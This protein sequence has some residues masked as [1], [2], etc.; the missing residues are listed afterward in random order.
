MRTN[1]TYI[2]VALI[3][4]IGIILAGYLVGNMHLNGLKYQRYVSVKGLAER[5]VDANLAIWAFRMTIASNE[6]NFL[7]KK[8]EDDTRV[9]EN[10]LS[11]EGF[12]T[13]EF[14]A[15]VAEIQDLQTFSYGSPN[16]S[17]PFR[18]IAKKDFTIRTSD[19]PKLHRALGNSSSLIGE[20][21]VL[22]SKNQWQGIE[23]L[24]TE[25][26]EIKPGMI[27]EATKN[28]REA[29]QKFAQDAG[30]KVGKIKSASQGLFTISDRDINTGYIKNVRIVT[31][32]D[33][34]LED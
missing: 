1:I 32:V 10:F 20:G 5:E 31:T 25:L 2:L 4:S 11:E 16:Q 9:I 33:F 21:I 14:S 27:E 23:Y 24:Y 17:N 29:A 3:L 6:L 18:Y 12:E 34:Y 7:Q 15:G 26:N 13:A 30:S 19:I 28:A 22:E 8:L